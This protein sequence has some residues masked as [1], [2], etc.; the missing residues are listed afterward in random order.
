MFVLGGL[1]DLGWKCRRVPRLDVTVQL[2]FLFVDERL[3]VD[4]RYFEQV[5]GEVQFGFT[6]LGG[7]RQRQILRAMVHK[8]QGVESEESKCTLVT[9]TTIDDV[10]RMYDTRRK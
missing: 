4:R 10:V 6:P 8:E 7:Y 1:I 3:H 5:L 2:P 9:V